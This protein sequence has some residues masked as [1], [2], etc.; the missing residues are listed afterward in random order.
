[1]GEQRFQVEVQSDFIE[2]QAKA[3]P[4][5]AVSEFIW[6]AVD[7]DATKVDVNVISDDMGLK[8]I[9]IRDNGHGMSYE[10]APKLF[11]RLGG[12]WKKAGAI[13]KGKGRVLHGHEGRGRFKAFALGRV[14]DWNVT[15]TDSEGTWV[16]GMTM[17]ADDLRNV[18]LSDK[19]AAKPHDI[20]TEVTITEFEKDFHSLKPD[21]AIQE[22][23]EI[24][25]LHLKN[26]RDITLSYN[27]QIVDPSTAI[28]SQK[29]FHLEPIDVD[30]T[31]YPASLEIIEWRNTTKRT[32]YLCCQA[33]FPLS[34]IPTRFHVGE[35]YF[36][37]YLKSP[38]IS[39][40]HNEEQ[41]DI[42]EMNP[43]LVRA[44]EEANGI[45]K[46]YFRR[47]AAEKA[48]S[49]VEVWKEEKVYPYQG[50]AQ[51]PLEI[52]ER[53]V[54]DYVATQVHDYLPNFDTIPAKNK[55][56]HLRMLRQAIEKS[57]NDLQ[58][59][60]NEV[61]GL[62][63]RKQQELAQLLQETSLSAIISAAKIVSDRLKMLSGLEL[64]LFDSDMKKNLKE[65]SQLHRILADN[66]WIFGE[67]F[68]LS[69]DDK[70][71]TEVLRKH[72]EVLG[73]DIIIDAPVKHIDKERGVIDLMFSRS[74]RCHRANQVEHLV[75][76]LKRPTVAIGS[77][78]ITQI[79]KY[80]L[81]IAADERFRN[82][83]TRWSFWI[84][85]D[86]ISKDKYA[87]HRILDDSGR[88]SSKDGMDIFVKTWS[89]I[90]EENKARLQFFQE[91]LEHK[92]DNG[93]ALKHL[94]AKYNDLLNDV[95][96]DEMVDKHSD[97][98]QAREKETVQ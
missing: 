30:G 41:L 2:R 29:T 3:S 74:M 12:S 18:R 89:Q 61:L 65:R 72:K 94:Q 5:Q 64:I 62:P 98:R 54:F 58:L 16:Y 10:N 7:A 78:E 73:E 93:D 71:L 52:A 86:D 27:G 32:L 36:S 88:I 13:T 21:T 20:G 38:F 50:T 26:Y 22:L 8:A 53:Q 28:E 82:I 81:S 44:A 87:Q 85:S 69:V 15:Y 67:E 19:K 70:G 31:P 59:I 23:A 75:V 60:M 34:Q 11:S 40:L 24:F 79:E 90:I 37:A 25:A 56:F 39:E 45:I 48:K 97:E 91:R 92:V 6:N 14:A 1:M 95:V 46:D 68:H 9:S 42:A 35:F 33:G 77:D 76:E 96:T 4:I 49:V 17:I 84:V 47:R 43:R 51:N 63:K 55:A 80:A 66:T 83:N 57:P